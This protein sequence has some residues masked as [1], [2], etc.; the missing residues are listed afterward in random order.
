MLA[1][2]QADENAIKKEEKEIEQAVKD[3]MAKSGYHNENIQKV[4]GRKEVHYC[5]EHYQPHTCRICISKTTV[6][7]SVTRNLFDCKV[8][9]DLIFTE[10]LREFGLVYDDDPESL[11]LIL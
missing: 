1:K 5:H 6:A 4:V 3:R 2:K 8:R 11:L 9:R 10:T 7:S